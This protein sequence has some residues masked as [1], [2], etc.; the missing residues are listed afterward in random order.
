MKKLVA[1]ILSGSALLSGTALG[2]DL[3]PKFYLGAEAQ[4]NRYTGPKEITT[5]NKARLSTTDNKPLFGR[6]GSTLNLFAGSKLN[7]YVGIELGYGFLNH[8]KMKSITPGFQTSSLKTKNHN[9]FAD[10]LGFMPLST[11]VDLIGSVG[12]GRLSSKLCGK[13]EQRVAGFLVNQENVS[14][15]SRKTG[16]RLGLGAQYKFN[17]NVGTRLMVRHQKGNNFIK[18]VNSLGVGLFYQF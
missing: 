16:L 1:I 2:L 12:I 10:V 7:E 15:R 5:P 6:S 18:K 8:Q 13:V 17:E 14:M 4:A 11:E 3:D 9:L